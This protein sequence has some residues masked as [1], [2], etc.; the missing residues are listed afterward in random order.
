MILIK[1]EIEEFVSRQIKNSRGIQHHKNGR[2]NGH[3]SQIGEKT[4]I[5]CPVSQLLL[6]FIPIVYL[7]T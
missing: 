6:A 4:F 1:S 7:A 2:L 5:V 3:K